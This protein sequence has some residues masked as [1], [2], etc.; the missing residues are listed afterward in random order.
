MGS[1]CMRN[2]ITPLM[3]AFIC[4]QQLEKVLKLRLHSSAFSEASSEAGTGSHEHIKSVKSRVDNIIQQ[5]DGI[6]GSLTF[7]SMLVVANTTAEAE[8]RTPQSR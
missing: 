6:A 2:A 1:S 8:K 3:R 4:W 5:P 7:N